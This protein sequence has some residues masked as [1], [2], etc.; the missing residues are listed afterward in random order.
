MP[1]T[2]NSTGN[3]DSLLCW[4]KM[5]AE[6]GQS[7]EDIIERKEGERIHNSGI[8]Y[9]GIGTSIG[10]IRKITPHK[11]IPL[12]FSR[13]LSK[14]QEVDV[15]PDFIFRWASFVD[16]NGEKKQLPSSTTILSRGTTK[17][18]IKKNHYALVCHSKIKLEF[19]Y[20]GEF[21]HTAYKNIS[22][23]KIG[24]SQVTAVITKDREES[25]IFSKYKI[26]MHANL[27]YPYCIKLCDPEE[28]QI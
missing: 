7:L 11:E 27:I 21:D 5:Q 23:K 6:S 10:D 1:K 4:T 2:Y 16:I 24:G 14:P 15:S 22:G 12:I 25:H 19:G 28:Y 18:G 13:M 3:F 17:T 20:F 8:F 26:N 9:W